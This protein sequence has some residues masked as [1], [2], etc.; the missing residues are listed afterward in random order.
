MFGFCEDHDKV[1]YGARHTLT[2]VRTTDNN[3][4]IF[5]ADAAGAGKVQLTKISWMM[6]KVQPND[7]MKY[8]LY[9]IILAKDKLDVGFRMRQCSVIQIPQ[10]TSLPWRLGVKTAPEKPRFNI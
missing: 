1:V 8:K 7:E 3:D 9:N 5:R 10:T 6:P 2:L 4:A